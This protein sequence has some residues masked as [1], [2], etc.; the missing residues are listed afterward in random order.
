[1]SIKAERWVM[2]LP[3]RLARTVPQMEAETKRLLTFAVRM[4]PKSVKATLFARK[5]QILSTAPHAIESSTGGIIRAKRARWLF[6]P[7][8]GHRNVRPGDPNLVTIPRGS[9][10]FKRYVIDKN[11]KQLVAVRVKHVTLRGSRW[12]ERAREA[13]IQDA[14]RRLAKQA[15]D[16]LTKGM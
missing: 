6:V 11:S 5:D 2:E 10:L 12:I 13:H 7:L 3:S 4:A 15:E 1:M 14:E 9:S 8:P 16:A